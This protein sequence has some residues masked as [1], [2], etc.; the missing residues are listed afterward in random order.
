MHVLLNLGFMTLADFGAA[1]LAQIPTQAAISG[2]GVCVRVYVGLFHQLPCEHTVP[3]ACWRTYSRFRRSVV[4]QE[5]PT[6]LQVHGRGAAD[7]S[8]ARRQVAH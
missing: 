1:I 3:G 6:L 4:C 5:Q 2:H 7:L 8:R